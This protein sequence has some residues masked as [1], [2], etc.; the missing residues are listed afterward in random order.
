V[1]TLEFAVAFAV[2]VLIVLRALAETLIFL[3]GAK[4]GNPSMS[5]SLSPLLDT[6]FALRK[7]MVPCIDLDLLTT[8]CLDF[9]VRAQ[10]A[11]IINC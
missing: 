5:L 2:F 10:K 4:Y 6:K 9:P 1:V 3:F 11:G 8:L 7:V